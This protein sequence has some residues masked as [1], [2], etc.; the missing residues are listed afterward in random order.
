MEMFQQSL[1]VGKR[2]P[3]NRRKKLS[4]MTPMEGINLK[5]RAGAIAVAPPMLFFGCLMFLF[6]YVDLIEWRSE[7]AALIA[8]GGVLVLVGF[9][10][11]VSALWVL[12]SLGRSPL[13]LRIGGTA[14]A[15]SGV[16]LATA[17]ATGVLQCSGPA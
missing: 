3:S 16:V 12:G 15:A 8:S 2:F 10:V 4:R 6:G 13:A 5:R 17:A 1:P 14:I 11:F 9:V 7:R